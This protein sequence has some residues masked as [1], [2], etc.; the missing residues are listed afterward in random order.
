MPATQATLIILVGLLVIVLSF[1]AIST[2]LGISPWVL[3]L[4]FVASLVGSRV[5]IPIWQ[6]NQLLTPGH[7]Y[8]AGHWFFYHPPVVANQVVAINVGGAIIPILFSLW[9]LPKAPLLRTVVATVVVAFVYH[10]LATPVPYRGI[11]V[12]LLVP[13]IVTAI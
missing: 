3:A 8:R 7:A 1:E 13:P 5:N 9:L 2:K 6:S 4:I 11:E 12:P 10:Q